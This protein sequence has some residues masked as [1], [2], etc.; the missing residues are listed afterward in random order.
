MGFISILFFINIAFAQV[1][2]MV[3]NEVCIITPV[4]Y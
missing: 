2:F 1:R 4:S 3:G